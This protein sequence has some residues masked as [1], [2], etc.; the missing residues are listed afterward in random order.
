M[1]YDT[2]LLLVQ[3]VDE[4]LICS[5]CY[6]L[7]A[8][9][10]VVC[11]ELHTLCKTCAENV[12]PRKCPLCQKLMKTKKTIISNR[13]I[14][15]IVGKIK[16][17]CM[18]S[19]NVGGDDGGPPA[20]K[21]KTS[22]S[23]AAPVSSVNGCPWTGPVGGLNKHAAECGF[24]KLRCRNRLC[25]V[26]VYR[27]DL[28]AH[29][30]ECAFRRVACSACKGVM[31]A[32]RFPAHV[33]NTCSKRLLAFPNNGCLQASIP[34]DQLT[35]HRAM[36]PCETLKCLFGGGRCNGTYKRGVGSGDHDREATQAHLTSQ[37]ASST[38]RRA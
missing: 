17:R 11:L 38:R 1:G 15:N 21:I 3:P 9:P 25:A 14:A 13:L 12:K 24:A 37:K 36:C 31:L 22:A 27:K 16:T 8:D 33:A 20:K 28:V 4:N 5:V 30:A 34:A 18:N 26:S 23:A 29:A 10:V 7:F 6:D 35:D 2:S 32:N 19:G